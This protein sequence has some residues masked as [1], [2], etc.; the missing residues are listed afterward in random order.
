[1]VVVLLAILN[2]YQNDRF[3]VFPLKYLIPTLYQPGLY[4][5]ATHVASTYLAKPTTSGQFFRFSIIKSLAHFFLPN[6]E[7]AY[8]SLKEKQNL[9]G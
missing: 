3:T 5:D 9:I 7:A 6:P 2:W 8:A 1:M 4:C